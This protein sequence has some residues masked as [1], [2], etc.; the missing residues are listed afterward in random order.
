MHWVVW[1]IDGATREITAATVPKGAV[2]GINDFKRKAYGG[3]CPPS[4][5]HRYFF[6]LYALNALLTLS[7]GSTKGDLEKAMKDHVLA[8]AELV[9]RFR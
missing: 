1:N 2:Q 8:R 9:G 7:S 5:T 6:K 4:G 3:P